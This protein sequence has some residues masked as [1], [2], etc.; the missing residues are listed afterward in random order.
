MPE[1]V[2]HQH[3]AITHL[4]DIL[5]FWIQHRQ[6]EDGQFG[7]G[8]GDDV[9]MWRW[10]TPLLLG[11]THPDITRA[12]EKL[13]TGIFALPRLEQGY[14]SILTDV[15]HSSEDS[16]DSISPMLLIQPDSEWTNRA[17][18]IGELASSLW[19]AENDV[20]GLQFQSTY[21]T[22]TEVDAHP[23]RACDTP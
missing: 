1:W 11:Y 13:S 4:M 5:E 7:G 14:T 22:S 8:W 16:A 17:L 18:R 10:W 3:V 12:Q 21:F 20:G 23:D 2:Q 15:E 6:A 19:F 9:E